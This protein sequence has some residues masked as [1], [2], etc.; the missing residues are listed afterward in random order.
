MAALTPISR[1]PLNFVLGTVAAAGAFAGVFIGAGTG[2]GLLGIIGT[3]ALVTA[4]AWVFITMLDNE[5]MGRWI[6]IL[7]LGAICFVLGGMAAG[8]IGLLTGWF[9]GWFIY[10]LYEGR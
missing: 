10:W 1:K 5:R 3:A 7:L 6:A 8:I 4:M 2:T 9:F